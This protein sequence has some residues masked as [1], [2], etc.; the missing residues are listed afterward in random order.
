MLCSS[1]AMVLY[2]TEDRIVHTN[3]AYTRMTGYTLS[4]VEGKNNYSALQGPLT[5][6]LA[7]QRCAVS[8]R[9]Q[10]QVSSVTVTNYRKGRTEH[11]LF[12]FLS[13]LSHINPTHYIS[14]TSV[15]LL[16]AIITYYSR[17]TH[18]SH[19]PTRWIAVQQSHDGG[20][21]PWGA[22]ESRD[23]ALL[24][25]HAR[26]HGLDVARYNTHPSHPHPTYSHILQFPYFAILHT[27]PCTSST[28]ITNHPWPF[29]SHPEPSPSPPSPPPTSL[30]PQDYHWFPS[31]LPPNTPV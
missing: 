8:C 27:N 24:C 13:T 14:L 6:V 10:E 31:S 7:V 20:T 26:G 23:Y 4:D 5:D 30:H 25:P 9:K 17:I 11:N 22:Y 15:L 3:K 21:R 2:D 16:S 18:S 12:H 28:Y 29:I 19:I 1:E